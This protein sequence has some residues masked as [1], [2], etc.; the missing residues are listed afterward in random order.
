MSDK[1]HTKILSTAKNT[2][3]LGYAA[4]LLIP[5]RVERQN[6]ETTYHAPLYK[7]SYKS[8]VS[9]CEDGEKPISTYTITS[10]GLLSDQIATTKRLCTAA[11]LKKPYYKEKAKHTISRAHDKMGNAISIAKT[12]ARSTAKTAKSKM[13]SLEAHMVRFVEEIIEM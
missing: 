5:Y 4:S 11:L 6:D 2:L 9:T 13:T 3:I 12:K 7:L 1:A 8:G 10:F